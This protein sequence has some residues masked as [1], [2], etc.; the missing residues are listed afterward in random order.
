ML[1]YAASQGLNPFH[2]FQGYQG[3]RVCGACHVQESLSWSTTHHA[4]AYYTLYKREKVDDPECVACHVV[5]LGEEGGFQLGDHSSSLTDVGCE[6]CHTASGPHDGR[7]TSAKASCAGC[8][9]EEHSIN[10]S[11]EKGLPHIDHYI[12]NRL[13]DKELRERIMAISE[14]KAERP[15]LAFNE[16]ETVG[17]QKCQECHQDVH[18]QDPHLNAYSSLARK[19][20]KKGNCVSC[21]A[22]PKK[23]GP[24]S[25]DV[26]DY[27]HNEGVGC[28]SCH[29]SG[30]EHIEEPSLDNIV[31]LGESCP[32]CVL[33]ALC[34]SCH[35]EEWDKDWEL[36]KRLTFYR[37]DE[38]LQS[39]SSEKDV[40]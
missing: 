23:L 17:A 22:T 34:T 39:S 7:Y 9:N 6:S 21:H 10:F 5:G 24:R 16:E 4:Q 1:R 32:E 30:K 33:E 14:G 18:S 36:Q 27:R 15:L 31:R 35:T 19:H 8:H 11:I 38:A 28:E 12:S 25:K 2:Y 13:S 29:G 3:S 40:E 37:G 26:N 20:R